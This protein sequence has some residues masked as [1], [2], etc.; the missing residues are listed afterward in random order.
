[1]SSSA[2]LAARH[3]IFA[4]T[5]KLKLC[6]A[7]RAGQDLDFIGSAIE[8][9]RVDRVGAG[10]AKMNRYT[11]RN[12]N[13]MR[14]EQVLLGNHSNGDRA[15]WILLGSEIILDELSRQVKRQRIDVARAPQ[16]MQQRN[17]D[18]IVARGWDQA[19]N[20]HGQQK[21]S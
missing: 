2:K 6:L 12:Q 13:A 19:Q 18:L 7:D 5:G 3:F 20:Q 15:I 8:G 1:M 9:K 16:P 17:V 11:S 4:R 14:D 10:D 21:R